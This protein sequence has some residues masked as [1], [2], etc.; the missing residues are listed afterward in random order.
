MVVLEE[1]VDRQM[2]LVL[3][4]VIQVEIIKAQEIHLLLVLRKVIMEV[5]DQLE[6]HKVLVVAVELVQLVLMQ[7]QLQVQVQQ[8]ELV[9]Q[10]LHLV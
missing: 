10:V 8:V 7:T 4:V 5:E 2:I 3:V 1:V 6:A 9:V